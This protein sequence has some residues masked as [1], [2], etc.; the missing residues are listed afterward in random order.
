MGDMM[1]KHEIMGY[2]TSDYGVK[3]S[4]SPKMKRKTNRWDVL[5]LTFEPSPSL[6][7]IWDA[8]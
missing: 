2:T 7:P 6:P 3:P 5:F 1:I 4:P 8:N